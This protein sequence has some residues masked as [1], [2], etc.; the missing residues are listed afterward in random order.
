MKLVAEKEERD[1]QMRRLH[2][3]EQ[4]EYRKTKEAHLEE[5]VPKATGR[6]A[7]LEKRRAETAYHRRERSPDV[8]LPEQDL[9]GTAGGDDFKSLL[10]A[11]KRRKEA[12]ENRRY[13]APVGP[14]Q[15]P[16]SMVASSSS[17]S[18]QSAG[19][20]VGSV[21]E[22]KQAAYREKEEKQMEAFRQLWAQ[23]QAAKKGL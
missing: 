9:M 10:M 14:D 19:G 22:A 3:K 12:R 5:L 4:K 7:M 2:R 17:S 16:S 6:E 11:E 20:N 15:G 23:S 13:G 18:Y 1:E 21:L 8:E